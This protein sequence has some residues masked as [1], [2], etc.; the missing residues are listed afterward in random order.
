MAWSDPVQLYC[1]RT[2]PGFWDEPLNAISNAAFLLIAIVAWQRWHHRGSGDRVT[3]AF[4]GLAAIIGG[5]S[6]I[7]H[8]LATRGAALFDTIPIAIFVYGYFLLALA[9][10]LGLPIVLAGLATVVFAALSMGLRAGLQG[11][12]N[13]SGDYLPALAGL[14]GIGLVLKLRTT[15]VSPDHARSESDAVHGVSH[16]L[17]EQTLRRRAAGRSL[18]LAALVFAISLV[19]RTIDISICDVVSVGTHFIWHGLNAVVLYIL[20]RTAIDFGSNK[21]VS[22]PVQS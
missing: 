22:T 17:F 12:F 1:E 19:F 15:P 14:I 6:F 20:L 4:V 18:L 3:L 9:R 11:A 21:A 10:Y 2:G 7:F 8:T 5:G 16:V 13:G